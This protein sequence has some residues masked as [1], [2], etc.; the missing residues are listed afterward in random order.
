MV[1]LKNFSDEILSLLRRPSAAYKSESSWS[2]RNQS[3][4][5]NNASEAVNLFFWLVLRVVDSRLASCFIETLIFNNDEPILAM[6]IFEVSGEINDSI[7]SILPF[8]LKL[9]VEIEKS[10][11]YKLG[12]TLSF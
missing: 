3:S 11:K 8:G 10:E 5:S 7:L 12:L 6:K 9:K 1:S 2:P 4:R